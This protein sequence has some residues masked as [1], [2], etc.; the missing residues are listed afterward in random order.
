VLRAEEGRTAEG[1]DRRHREFEADGCGE[2]KR[3][4]ADC[5]AGGEM[6]TR[7]HSLAGPPSDVG[8]GRCGLAAVALRLGASPVA[9]L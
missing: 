3:Q 5:V 1:A 9:V 6:R 8:W 4:L 2:G 7:C